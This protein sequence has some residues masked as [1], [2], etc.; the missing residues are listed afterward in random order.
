ME[1]NTI[2]P[3]ETTN[4]GQI[5]EVK[6]PTDTPLI[7]TVEAAG[8][9]PVS[10]EASVP[11]EDN[12]I[13]PDQEQPV[14]AEQ[15]ASEA[16]APITPLPHKASAPIAAIVAAVLVAIGLA[17]VTVY[18]YQKTQNDSKATI[19]NKNTTQTEVKSTAKEVDQTVK[20]I[21]DTL[22]TTDD[23]KDFPDSEI[24]DQSLGL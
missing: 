9:P 5:I 21:D 11:T 20:E 16:P 7:P 14:E 4:P 8:D 17:A 6:T 18:A 23:A 1:D 15:P 22:T 2:K 19:T 24:T 3:D 12:A 13:R 10:E